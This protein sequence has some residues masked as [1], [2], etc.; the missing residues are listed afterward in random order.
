MLMG[1]SRLWGSELSTRSILSVS[2]S[3][4]KTRLRENRILLL[5][6]LI[7]TILAGIATEWN[8]RRQEANFAATQ[9]LSGELEAYKAEQQ[10]ILEALRDAN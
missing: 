8:H 10:E 7:P 1:L 2:S 5:L 3:M 6:V 4:L 9:Q